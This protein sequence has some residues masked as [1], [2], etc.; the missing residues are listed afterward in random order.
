VEEPT[1]A[2]LNGVPVA[3][4]GALVDR[5]QG[6]HRLVAAGPYLRCLE[7]L[8][9]VE[10]DNVA[11]ALATLSH[12]R[13][14]DR[15]RTAWQRVML[16]DDDS[17]LPVLRPLP[18]VLL[19]YLR[20]QT[21]RHAERLDAALRPDTPK[22]ER[23]RWHSFGW[24]AAPSL[25]ARYQEQ[26]VEA[27]LAFVAMRAGCDPLDVQAAADD[28][29]SPVGAA[30]RDVGSKQLKLLNLGLRPRVTEDFT[31]EPLVV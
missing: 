27:G 15:Y 14:C 23:R 24:R 20:E 1:P 7:H 12:A 2:V 22:R 18:A 26:G 19:A 16:A 29:R 5:N 31:Y 3:V 8:G 28:S 11:A 21:T 6:E 25:A 9:T 17:F 13:T 10:R 4:E 30:L